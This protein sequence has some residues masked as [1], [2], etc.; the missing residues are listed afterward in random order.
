MNKKLTLLVAVATMAAFIFLGTGLAQANSV[1]CG[2]ILTEDTTLDADLDCSVIGGTAFIIG[3]DGI[4][5]DLNG[6][7]VTG[8]GTGRGVDNSGGYILFGD[9]SV[10]GYDNVTIKNG[11]IDGFATG[12]FLVNVS[13]NTLSELEIRN[14]KTTAGLQGIGINLWLNCRNNIVRGNKIHDNERQ[15]ILLGC[16]PDFVGGSCDGLQPM[17]NVIEDNEIYSNGQVDDAYGIQLLFASKNT[18]SKNTI[19]DH[20]VNPSW[21]AV[22]ISVFYSSK[23]TIEENEVTDNE[24]GTVVYDYFGLGVTSKNTFKDNEFKNSTFWDIWDID[25]VKSTWIGN[26]CSISVPDGLCDDDD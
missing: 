24:Y 26:E 11:V 20:L 17:N 21:S 5:L 9:P 7:T 23:N 3:A 18:V 22:G 2:D 15:G 13:G 16:Y 4:T 6:H 14:S 19:Y 10:A 12:V 1:S 8:D 25:G